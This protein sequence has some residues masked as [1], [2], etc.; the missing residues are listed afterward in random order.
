[1]V[2]L[3]YRLM[4]GNQVILTVKQVTITVWLRVNKYKLAYLDNYMYTAFRFKHC[5]FHPQ[6]GRFFY[7]DNYL[8]LNF[9]IEFDIRFRMLFHVYLYVLHLSNSSKL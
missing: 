7:Q 6:Q 3:F 8:Y 2:W 4:K 1:M 9:Y 5:E